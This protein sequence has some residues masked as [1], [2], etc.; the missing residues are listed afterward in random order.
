LGPRY[1]KGDPRQTLQKKGLNTKFFK[2]PSK[3]QPQDWT[4]VT[5]HHVE[6][7]GQRGVQAKQKHAGIKTAMKKSKQKGKKHQQ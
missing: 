7:R 3:D 2:V 1:W 6:N 5:S 4:C